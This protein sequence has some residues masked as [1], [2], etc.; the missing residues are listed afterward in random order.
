MSPPVMGLVRRNAYLVRTRMNSTS[1]FFILLKAGMWQ[2]AEGS[3]S[4]T[5]DWEG[6]YT[7]ANQQ[8]VTGIVADGI[9]VM[10]LEQSVPQPIRDRFIADTSY[11]TS[12]NLKTVAVQT[13]LCRM[14]EEAGI[15]YVII[16]GQEA[17]RNYPNPLLRV[18][19]DIDVL[20]PQNHYERAKELLLKIGTN[21]TDKSLAGEYSIYVDGILVELHN[22]IYAGINAQCVNGFEA[23]ARDVFSGRKRAVPDAGSDVPFVPSD[24]FNAIYLLVHA[25]RHLGSFGISLRQILDWVMHLS[26]RSGTI[27]HAELGRTIDALHLRNLYGLFAAFAREYLGASD[28]ALGASGGIV[29]GTHPA[30]GEL[31]SIIRRS[32][33][34]GC[35]SPYAGKH[36]RSHIHER[37]YRTRFLL[38]QAREIKH[39]DDEFSRYL[40]R[41]VTADFFD[42]LRRTFTK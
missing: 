11:I 39:I 37:L 18:S 5:P 3:L 23:L 29:P 2:K 31:W 27:N 38:G 16:K 22:N 32:G 6:I 21:P 19:G 7:L 15:C 41:R 35:I 26:A 28:E 1:D 9:V 42:S 8:A 14:M 13:R 4:L 36:F 34:F 10:G 24:D 30:T 33:N 40:T 17:A 12:T 25:I 20:L